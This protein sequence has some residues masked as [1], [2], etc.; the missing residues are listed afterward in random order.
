MGYPYFVALHSH[1]IPMSFM[2]IDNYNQIQSNANSVKNLRGTLIHITSFQLMLVQFWTL[3][4][5]FRDTINLWTGSLPIWC[6]YD[7]DF[8]IWSNPLCQI[9]FIHL[10]YRLSFFHHETP[11][12]LKLAS[13]EVYWPGT[14]QT[15]TYDVAALCASATAQMRKDEKSQ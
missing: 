5:N 14:G 7:S 1:F 9:L 12:K 13:W 3:P 4:S 2:R 6:R 8:L 15:K 11:K 10:I